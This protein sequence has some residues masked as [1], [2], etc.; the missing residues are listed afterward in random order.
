M[1]KVYERPLSYAEG[2]PFD[3]MQSFYTALYSVR[4]SLLQILLTL[5]CMYIGEI[6]KLL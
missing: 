3:F 6:F 2:K 1:L 4:H 5:G